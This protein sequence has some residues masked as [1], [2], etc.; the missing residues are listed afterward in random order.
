MFKKIVQFEAFYQLKQ[1]AFPIFALL[2]LA[3]GV[4]VGRQGHAPTGIHFNAPFQVY[5]YTSL[6]TLGSVFI[7]MFFAVSAM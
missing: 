6:F 3:L 2:F 1:R 5:F 4:F 7:I